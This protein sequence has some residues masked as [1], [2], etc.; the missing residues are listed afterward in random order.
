MFLK[1][2]AQKS[3]ALSSTYAGKRILTLFAEAAL[4]WASSRLAPS[5]I[6]NPPLLSFR[7]EIC[8]WSTQPRNE[9]KL[10]ELESLHV[11]GKEPGVKAVEALSQ[12]PVKELFHILIS[13]LF[14][15]KQ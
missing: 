14:P 3:E 5:E 10:P 12:R 8:L 11:K 15:L 7:T 6:V 4:K 1:S 13:R 2:P 9:W